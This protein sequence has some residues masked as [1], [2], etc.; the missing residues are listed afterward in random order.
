MLKIIQRFGK[1]CNYHLQGKY[2][3]VGRFWKLYIGQAVDGE[4]DFMV[5]IGRAEERAGIQYSTRLI[6]VSRSCSLN[7]SRENLRIRI[8]VFFLF[9]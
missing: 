8:F 9:G 3:M 2:V 5:L 7:S 6:P 1:H 4:L